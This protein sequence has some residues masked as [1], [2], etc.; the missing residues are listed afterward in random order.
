MARFS[1]QMHAAP[2]AHARR[3]SVD[4]GDALLYAD[5]DAVAG[6]AAAGDA[7]GA[8]AL[9]HQRGSMPPLGSESSSRAGLVWNIPSRGSSSIPSPGKPGGGASPSQ[10]R[11][12]YHAQQAGGGDA[13][14]GGFGQ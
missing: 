12:P 14:G 13:M 11:S 7:G 5:L 9:H 4:D 1:P 3:P 6:D 8:G 2:A 10:P